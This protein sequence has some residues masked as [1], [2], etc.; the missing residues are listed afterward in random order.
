MKIRVVIDGR[1]MIK[2]KNEVARVKAEGDSRGGKKSVVE[3]AGV[4]TC[5][6]QRCW[7]SCLGDSQGSSLKARQERIKL[8]QGK[9]VGIRFFKTLLCVIVPGHC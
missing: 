6:I 2:E 3:M 4:Q 8:Y 9:E 5:A 7:E 1:Q